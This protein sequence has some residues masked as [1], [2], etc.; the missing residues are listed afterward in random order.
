[1]P[2]S[3]FVDAATAVEVDESGTPAVEVTGVVEGSIPPI[4]WTFDPK[5]ATGAAAPAI[6]GDD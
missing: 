6:T 2:S 5:V 3:G 1:M 4:V